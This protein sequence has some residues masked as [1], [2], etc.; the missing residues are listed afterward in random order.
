MVV[1]VVLGSPGVEVIL[2]VC[3]WGPGPV[4]HMMWGTEA[5]VSSGKRFTVLCPAVHRTAPY[6]LLYASP[7]DSRVSGSSCKRDALHR[8]GFP[9]FP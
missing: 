1:L 7:Q 3:F 5:A 2:A 4:M 8:G 6:L 9:V